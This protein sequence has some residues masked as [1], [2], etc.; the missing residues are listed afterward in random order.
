MVNG[1]L[2]SQLQGLA[3][4]GA[5]V[6][7]IS[8]GAAVSGAVGARYLRHLCAFVD[9]LDSSITEIWRL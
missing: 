6:S 8:A 2:C 9:D 1:S 5:G 3:M 7:K 4:S